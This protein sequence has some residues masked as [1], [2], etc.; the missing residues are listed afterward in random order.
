VGKIVAAFVFFLG[1]SALAIHEAK[2]PPSPVD[3]PR[4]E[5]VDVAPP[6][7]A[8]RDEVPPWVKYAAPTPPPA[9]PPVIKPPLVIEVKPRVII[10]ESTIEYVDVVDVVDRCPDQPNDRDDNDGCPEPVDGRGLD[11]RVITLVE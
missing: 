4:V 10:T 2:P 9:P 11:D 5:P 6:S 1:A 8:V 7:R 3:P